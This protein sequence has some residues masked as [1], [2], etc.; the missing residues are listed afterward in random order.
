[1]NFN[2]KNKTKK[3]FLLMPTD[4]LAI[5]IAMFVLVFS[6]TYFVHIK[7]Y[8]Q[9]SEEMNEEKFHLY[10]LTVSDKMKSAQITDD[11]KLRITELCN[12]A[13]VNSI[14]DLTY[15]KYTCEEFND[16][17]EFSNPFSEDSSVWGQ[18]YFES[19]IQ[20]SME[21]LFRNDDHFIKYKRELYENNNNLCID[22]FGTFQ[23]FNQINLWGERGFLTLNSELINQ[24]EKGNAI[25]SIPSNNKPIYF[26]VCKQLQTN[27]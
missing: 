4:V 22:S 12:D 21:E 11:L 17:F 27:H 9:N 25:I 24:I 16:L 8:S 23:N 26:A 15:L 19:E 10:A 20:D 3:G 5:V 6:Y 1:M 18:T 2:A 14:Q 13:K 7:D